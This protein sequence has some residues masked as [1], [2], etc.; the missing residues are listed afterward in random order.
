MPKITEMFAFVTWNKDPDDEGVIGFRSPAGWVPMV[1]ADMDRVES[2]KSI[3]D[4]I[5][6]VH[7]KPYIIKKFKLVEEIKVTH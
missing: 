1:G 5:T 3:A 2:L 4:D 6:K 7:G